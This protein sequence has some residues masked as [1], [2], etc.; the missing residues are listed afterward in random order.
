MF[1][2]KAQATKQINQAR[3]SVYASLRICYKIKTKTVLTLTQV[4]GMWFVFTRP[5]IVL[6]HAVSGIKALF[7]VSVLSASLYTQIRE[8]SCTGHRYNKVWN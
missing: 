1:N 3:R 2:I 6:G 8:L 5:D 7:P 4:L